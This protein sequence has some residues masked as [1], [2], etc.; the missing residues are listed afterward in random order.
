MVTLVITDCNKIIRVLTLIN[1]K[2][3]FQ[4]MKQQS[5]LFYSKILVMLLITSGTEDLDF[6]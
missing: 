5:W 1:I 3:S 2:S 6:V 4:T